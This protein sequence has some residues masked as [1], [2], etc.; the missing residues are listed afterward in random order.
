MS[1]A[2]R[3]RDQMPNSDEIARLIPHLTAAEL[4]ELDALL[5]EAEPFVRLP[6]YP[7]QAALVDDP[8][9]FTIT[10]ASSKAGK[11]VSHLEWLIAEASAA[12]SGEWWWVA[13]TSEVADIA[14]R[15]AL[16]RLQGYLE[17]GGE[18]RKVGEPYPHTKNLTR[19]FVIVNGA[20]I[21]FKS[22]D[23][24]DSLYGEDVRAAVGD[25]VTRWREPA[26]HALYTT[27]TATKGRAKLIGNVK[28]RKNFAYQLARKAEAG[29]PGWSYHRLTAFDAIEGGVIER[30]TVEQ[31]ERD[32]PAHVFRELYLA[33]AGDDVGNPFGL[34]AI[35]ACTMAGFSTGTPAVWGWDLAKSVDWTVGIA[36]DRDGKECR[37]E[38]WQGPWE[39]TLRRILG[40]TGTTPALVDS[41]G[42][43]DP[44][45]ERLQRGGDGHNYAGFKFSA[46]S[47]QQLMEGLAVA[48]QRYEV[49]IAPGVLVS[50]MESFEYEYTRT[51]VRYSAPSGMHDDCVC[52]LALAWSRLREA[53][54]GLGATVISVGEGPS[55]WAM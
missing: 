21:W 25:E 53:Q 7:K 54:P 46:P 2:A 32:L 11:T 36:L 33:E 24:P 50:E 16:A 19:R 28:G 26:W 10:E 34:D 1:E 30:A 3:A 45:V 17:S 39:E 22:A 37:R 12:G 29:E 49:G 18:R 40:L 15:R 9:R 52:A 31:A 44:V 13:T 47:K 4:A 8:A 38:R 42:V 48:V 27:L 35:R 6:L 23:E 5:V 41:T 43:G 51:G 14:F 20:T 55:Y